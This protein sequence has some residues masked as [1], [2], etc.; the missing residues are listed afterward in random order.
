MMENILTSLLDHMLSATALIISLFA[1]FIALWGVTSSKINARMSRI[2]QV[3]NDLLFDYR[4]PDMLLAVNNLWQFYH[5]K[6]DEMC[7]EYEIL[8]KY[9]ERD[10][11]NTKW[12]DK[13]GF[14]RSSLH[15]QRRYV[16]QFYAYLAGI[17]ELKIVPRKLLHSYWS[18]ADLRII[19]DI[20]I[21][22]EKSMSKDE[23]KQPHIVLRR[24][25]KLYDK[26]PQD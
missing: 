17:Y 12:E 21:P 5:D 14:V 1:T 22:I 8:R 3:L 18:K 15:F 13:I 11:I 25:E 2:H 20:I 4:S 19:P 7:K 24:M 26:W 9:T 23:E 16:S 10:Y 6:K